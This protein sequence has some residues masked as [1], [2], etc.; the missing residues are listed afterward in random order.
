[1]ADFRTPFGQDGDRR[2]PSIT[3]KEQGFPCG[4]ADRAL[5]NA[6]IYRL[7]AELG[8]LVDYAGIVGTDDRMSN[9]R[10]AV[11]ALISA[12]VAAIPADQQPDLSGYLTMAMAQSRLPI[13]P[14]VNNSTGRLTVT[15]PNV[16]VIRLGGG[17]TFLHRGI[18]PI[19]TAQLDFPTDPS[20]TYHLRWD[21][22]NGYR[23]RSLSDAAYNPSSAAET[24]TQFDSKYDDMLIAR[25][26]TTAANV[27]TITVLRNLDRFMDFMSQGGATT[28]VP[29][30]NGAKRTG[31]MIYD[32]SRTPT[33]M[34]FIMGFGT[35]PSPTSS[36][37][38][39]RGADNHDHDTTLT[40][41]NITRYGFDYTVM[42]DYASTITVGAGIMM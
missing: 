31:R 2:F 9:V 1:M 15:S 13:F 17:S 23:L 16:G 10:E 33:V 35:G 32:L 38:T 3:E 42:R 20:R 21:K 28:E 22:V 40:P 4:P 19:T 34:P 25:I 36:Y 29:L 24:S 26:T 6:L 41:A 7:E 12:A 27:A 8:H 14:H 30:Q 11:E 18:A 5:F 39:F 37:T